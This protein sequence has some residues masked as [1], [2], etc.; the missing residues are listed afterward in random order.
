MNQGD[1]RYKT[2]AKDTYYLGS[3]LSVISFLLCHL[4]LEAIIR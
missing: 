1:E 3:I 2:I 4:L